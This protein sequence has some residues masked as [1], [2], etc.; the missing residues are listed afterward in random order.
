MVSILPAFLECIAHR[1]RVGSAGVRV[2]ARGVWAGDKQYMRSTHTLLQ[3]A[4]LSVL[5]YYGC[6]YLGQIQCAEPNKYVH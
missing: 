6:T 2:G 4:D 3:A 5:G 1:D